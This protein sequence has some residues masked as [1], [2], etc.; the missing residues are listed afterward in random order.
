[1]KKLLFLLLFCLNACEEKKSGEMSLFI[2]TWKVTEM[3]TYQ[4]AKCSGEIDDTEWR[5]L[6]GKG[7]TITLEIYD[8]DTGKEIITGPNANT[9]T[10]TWYDVGDT[11]CF[12]GDCYK[13]EMAPN[14]NSFFVNVEEES[15][16]LDENYEVTADTSERE[17]VSA[18]T[19]NQW[20]PPKCHKTKYKKQI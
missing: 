7:L 18:S 16:C 6:K 20:F 17:C 15:Y 4:S 12:S 19:S 2:G 1:M 13:Y 3:G 11:F 9:T 8:D 14:N 10:F 5:G